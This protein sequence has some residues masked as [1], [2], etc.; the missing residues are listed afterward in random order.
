[1]VGLAATVLLVIEVILLAI[2]AGMVQ[3]WTYTMWDVHTDLLRMWILT[4]AGTRHGCG[5]LSD[6]DI[7]IGHVGPDGISDVDISDG[8]A[9]LGDSPDVA[10]GHDAHTHFGGSGLHL[11]TCRGLWHFL[12]YL[13]GPDC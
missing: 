8:T 10:A 2:G 1:M 13:A 7:H 6:M 4:Q 11:F 12:Q 3:M 5:Q 9:P